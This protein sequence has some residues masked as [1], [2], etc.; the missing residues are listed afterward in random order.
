MVLTLFMF[1]KCNYIWENNKTPRAVNRGAGV[2]LEM[3][4][5]IEKSEGNV[6]YDKFFTKL[7]FAP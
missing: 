6:T 1:E 4:K 5:E 2:V 3:T 7:P